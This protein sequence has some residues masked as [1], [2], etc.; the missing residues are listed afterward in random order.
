MQSSRNRGTIPF[1]FFCTNRDNSV[2][3]DCSEHVYCY[4]TKLLGLG[5]AAFHTDDKGRRLM[6]HS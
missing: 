1:I 3:W 5:V 4:Y 6:R 2:K